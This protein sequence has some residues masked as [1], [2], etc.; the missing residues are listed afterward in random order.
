[1]VNGAMTNATIEFGDISITL[2]HTNINNIIRKMLYHRVD[3]L[4]K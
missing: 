3:R 4:Y 2:I 1:M